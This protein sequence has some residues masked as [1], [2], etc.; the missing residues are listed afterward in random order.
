[1]E[2]NIT[3]KFVDLIYDLIGSLKGGGI[4]Q[5]DIKDPGTNAI[6]NNNTLT[7]I[8]NI[9]SIRRMTNIIFA[10][11]NLDP[12]LEKQFLSEEP[13]ISSILNYYKNLPDQVTQKD[14]LYT[15]QGISK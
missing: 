13:F 7:L 9:S 11:F 8:D 10:N 6:V 1:M 15:A 4:D 2:I 3:Q 5:I 12:D 14:I